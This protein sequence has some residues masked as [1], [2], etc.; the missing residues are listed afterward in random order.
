[1]IP[2]KSQFSIP[3]G[4]GIHKRKGIRDTIERHTQ[5]SKSRKSSN[6]YFW[7]EN[8]KADFSFVA[9]L[10]IQSDILQLKSLNN[11][12]EWDTAEEEVCCIL[13]TQTSLCANNFCSSQNS[14]HRMVLYLTTFPF[15]WLW[16]CQWCLITLLP[17]IS[18]MVM[19]G[20]TWPM[21]LI[22]ASCL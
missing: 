7:T 17:I 6:C 10:L 16:S 21:F 3:Y 15:R 5:N 19:I 13:I 8:R 12:R 14:N 20:E 22:K 4:V 9:C 1:M 2:Y 18:R 11:V